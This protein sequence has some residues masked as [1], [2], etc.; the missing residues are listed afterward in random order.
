MCGFCLAIFL[1]ELLKGF[2]H[3][4][5]DLNMVIEVIGPNTFHLI[6]DVIQPI[7]NTFFVLHDYII[8]VFC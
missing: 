3:L 2:Y 4:I 5:E 8:T 7:I 1:D 6:L